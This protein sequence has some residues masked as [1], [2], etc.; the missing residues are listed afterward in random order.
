MAQAL[1]AKGSFEYSSP[2]PTR[3]GDLS[4]DDAPSSKLASALTSIPESAPTLVPSQNFSSLGA[5]PKRV[6]ASQIPGSFRLTVV[7]PVPTPTKIP[8]PSTPAYN[9]SNINNNSGA[10][11]N[12]SKKTLNPPPRTTRSR[13]PS[14]SVTTSITTTTTTAPPAGTRKIAT[15]RLNALASK[16][17]RTSLAELLKKR[18][19]DLSESELAKVTRHHTTNNQDY[20][21]CDLIL[22][23]VVVNEARPDSPTTRM[24]RN[25][26]RKKMEK[27][28]HFGKGG[29]FQLDV[30]TNEEGLPQVLPRKIKWGKVYIQ[31]EDSQTPSQWVKDRE[32]AKSLL[33]SL[34]SAADEVGEAWGPMKTAIVIQRR[35]FL[36]DVPVEPEPILVTVPPVPPV[37]PSPAPTHPSNRKAPGRQLQKKLTPS[38][39]GI[40]TGAKRK[41]V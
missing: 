8:T 34:I 6:F 39:G 5:S 2:K 17:T 27:T 13:V 38:K 20:E 18:I 14:S 15:P 26:E 9:N 25:L 29:E 4:L 41:R 10:S 24:E 30:D 11:N 40:T 1:K 16:P 21:L 23:E 22:H 19:I 7:P 36:E 31:D 3:K 12:I 33:K 35:L 37:A 32:P 28:G